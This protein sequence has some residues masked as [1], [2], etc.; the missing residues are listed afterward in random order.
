MRERGDEL[1]LGAGRRL[2]RFSRH[3]LGVPR[4]VRADQEH[5]GADD[6]LSVVELPAVHVGWKS[7]RHDHRLLPVLGRA[8]QE[9]GRGDG[10]A[11]R[12]LQRLLL[13]HLRA[14]RDGGESLRDLAQRV[15][16]GVE[17]RRLAGHDLQ[18]PGVL[19]R[20]PRHRSEVVERAH[21]LLAESRR[22]TPSQ[23]QGSD[24]AALA[25]DRC[26]GFVHRAAQAL[27]LQPAVDA[28][29][30]GDEVSQRRL[31]LADFVQRVAVQH[32]LVQ[33]HNPAG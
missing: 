17:P 3:A 24:D 13:E 30:L 22:S 26:E 6:P 2:G 4:T 16:C 8:R 14:L 33:V 25:S 20:D 9:R 10:H 5:G 31:A 7:N 27:R 11:H 23:A 32:V 28:L 12:S 18:D 29:I 19:D 15:E 1:I 21:I